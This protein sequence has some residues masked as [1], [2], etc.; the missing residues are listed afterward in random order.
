MPATAGLLVKT[1]DPGLLR[2]AL[3]TVCY[4]YYDLDILSRSGDIHNQSRTLQKIDS[5]FACFWPPIFCR[6]GTP[7][8]LDLIRQ[9]Q[10]DSD[11]VAKFR[12]DRPRDLG[13]VAV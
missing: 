1:F 13:D 2:F 9:F 11:H 7:K 3:W 8:F 4:D 5:N 10:R 6:G 12:G